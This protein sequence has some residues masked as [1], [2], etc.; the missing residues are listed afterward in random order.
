MKHTGKSFI[1][2]AI[3]ALVNSENLL[4]GIAA[5]TVLAAFNVGGVTLHKLFQ[6][7]VEH[8]MFCGLILKGA[9]RKGSMF[10]LHYKVVTTT[11]N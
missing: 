2:E 5:P 11:Y 3:R 7:P 9:G 4:C 8:A 6:L 10:L 1:I